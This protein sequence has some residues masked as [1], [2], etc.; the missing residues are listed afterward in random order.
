MQKRRRK[1]LREHLLS[2]LC[3][4]HLFF[5]QFPFG[6]EIFMIGILI[7]SAV[8]REPKPSRIISQ[9]SSPW[10]R[11][12]CRIWFRAPGRSGH[13]PSWPEARPGSFPPL[14]TSDWF[15][16]RFEHSVWSRI[17]VSLLEFWYSWSRICRFRFWPCG[18]SST[19]TALRGDSGKS[20]S[21]ISFTCC[22]VIQL[23]PETCYMCWSKSIILL[24]ELLKSRFYWSDIPK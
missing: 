18:E 12:S 2:F 13:S 14:G 10:S 7:P 3:V 19:T 24:E 9:F 20:L 8:K 16:S 1:K 11:S 22:P 6:F 17:G 5:F 21:I 4:F 23:S 15:W